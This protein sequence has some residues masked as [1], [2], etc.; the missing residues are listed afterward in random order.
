MIMFHSLELRERVFSVIIRAV[1]VIEAK[2]EIFRFNEKIF[3]II[4]R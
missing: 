2:P 1:K 4:E 3:V